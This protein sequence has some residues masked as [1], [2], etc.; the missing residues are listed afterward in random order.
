MPVQFCSPVMVVGGQLPLCSLHRGLPTGFR[1]AVSL[2][3]TGRPRRCGWLDIPVVQ[4]AHLLSHF[5]SINLTKL[6][7]MS[8]LDEIKIGESLVR[9]ADMSRILLDVR[10]QMYRCMHVN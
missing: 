7:V 4:H 1:M 10:V 3:S 9:A 8:F 6:D 5:T 2:Y